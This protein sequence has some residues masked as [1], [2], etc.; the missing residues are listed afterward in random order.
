MARRPKP[1]RLATNIRL[2]ADVQA[3]L[4]GEVRSPDGTTIPGLAC[5]REQAVR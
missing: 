5:R 1:A 4:A 2:H 3:R